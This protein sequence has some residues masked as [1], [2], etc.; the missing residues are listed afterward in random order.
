MSLTDLGIGP[1]TLVTHAFVTRY[2]TGARHARA[3]AAAL[4]HVPAAAFTA[5]VCDILSQLP[6]EIDRVWLRRGSVARTV[7]L[8]N[9]YVTV[10]CLSL[11]VY[12][13]P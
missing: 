9:R 3:A 8:L 11:Q 1:S 4:T 7:Y 13:A 6:E 2:V 10:I 12:G 5:L